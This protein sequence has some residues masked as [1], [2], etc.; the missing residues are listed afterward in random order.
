[1]EET[2]KYTYSIE[3]NNA[4]QFMKK[5]FEE[6]GL[7]IDTCYIDYYGENCPGCGGAFKLYRREVKG[8]ATVSAFLNMEQQKGIAYCLCKKCVKEMS[9]LHAKRD[10]KITE[11]RIF[12]KIPDLRRT[13]KASKGQIE[14]ERRILQKIYE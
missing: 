13:K 6:A 5:K 10:A 11:E 9:V 7:E 3:I 4:L 14:L 8:V 12:E 1:M 2:E